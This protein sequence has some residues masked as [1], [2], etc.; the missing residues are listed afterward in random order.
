MRGDNASGRPTTEQW[1]RSLGIST[2]TT[3]SALTVHDPFSPLT[4]RQITTRALVLHGVIAAACGVKPGPIIDW[5]TSQGVWDAVSPNERAFL[6][7]PGAVREGD[8]L[9]FRWR[10]EAEWALLWVVE[11]V[12]HLGLPTRECDT[13][14]LVN[15]IIPALGSDIEPF[16]SSAKLRSPGELLAEDDRHYELWCNYVRSRREQPDLLPFDLNVDVLYQREYAFEWLGGIE[17]W[18]DVQCDT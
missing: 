7:D 13:G 8:R 4:A 15:N 6:R 14:R 2:A 1:A 11:K 12:D 9:R 10:Q 17:T 3:P 5:Y 16:L 18:D